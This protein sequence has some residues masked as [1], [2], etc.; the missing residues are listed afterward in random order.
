MLR[1]DRMLRELK[2]QTPQARMF[3]KSE[4]Y[5]TLA[6][7]NNPAEAHRWYQ[8]LETMKLGPHN[9][10]RKLRDCVSYRT[11]ISH[12]AQLRLKHNYIF[13]ISPAM[14]IPSAQ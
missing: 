13:S 7:F 11:V 2:G 3:K 8:N 10:F 9:Q 4:H 12:M 6:N 1:I 14:F 5:L